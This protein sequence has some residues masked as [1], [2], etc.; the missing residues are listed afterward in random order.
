MAVMSSV[1]YDGKN[2]GTNCDWVKPNTP[3]NY[4]DMKAY[5]DRRAEGLQKRN[6]G[7]L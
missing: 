5:V 2:R 4:Y 7:S 1:A 3:D 6:K